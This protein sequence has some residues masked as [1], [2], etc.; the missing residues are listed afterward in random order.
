MMVFSSHCN[1]LNKLNDAVSSNSR[2]S[3]WWI[4]FMEL[5]NTE[6]C[7]ALSSGDHYQRVSSTY[8][9]MTPWARFESTQN[10]SSSLSFAEWSNGG[11][12]HNTTNDN[13]AILR[14]A[15]VSRITAELYTLPHFNKFKRNLLTIYLIVPELSPLTKKS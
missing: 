7:S 12:N 4:V 1:S 10:L 13:A 6:G 9:S 2:C 14:T 8:T 11:D 15:V 3:W 5:L